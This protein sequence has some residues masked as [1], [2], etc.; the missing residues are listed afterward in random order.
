MII[1]ANGG[2]EDVSL[3]LPVFAHNPNV[4]IGPT[5]DR[6]HPLHVLVHQ[7]MPGEHNRIAVASRC[8]CS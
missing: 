5:T 2:E 6:L 3:P 4:D 1:A 7:G 8:S